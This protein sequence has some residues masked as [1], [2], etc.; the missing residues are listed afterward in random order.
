M[1]IP[2]DTIG[3]DGLEIDEVV[4]VSWLEKALGSGAPF[5]PAKDGRLILRLLRADE[6][7]HVSGRAE[8]ELEARC[9]RCLTPTP[10][11]LDTPIN[12]ALF[13]KGREPEPATD[14]EV[15]TDDLG[16]ATYEDEEV[17]LAAVVHD[18]VFLE[19]PM[20]PLC[21]ES[22]AGLCPTCGH[23]L[24]TGP[25]GCRPKADDRWQ[26]LKRIKLES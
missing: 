3:S 2:I 20:V 14:G 23:D 15:N 7:V 1:R 8:V 22:C 24:N 5:I 11:V 25:C 17:D 12:V 13:P 21:R 16:V 26:A 19:L 4:G 9:S 18:E 10:I 6:I